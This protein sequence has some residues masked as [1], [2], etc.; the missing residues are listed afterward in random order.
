MISAV[1]VTRPA[2]MIFQKPHRKR[3]DVLVYREV[4]FNEIGKFYAVIIN[5]KDGTMRETAKCPSYN[6]A[7]ETGLKVAIN[8]LIK[9]KKTQEGIVLFLKFN[10]FS[11]LADFPEGNVLF[12][13][14]F[15]HTPRGLKACSEVHRNEQSDLEPFDELTA[16]KGIAVA[17]TSIYGE[18]HHI[19]TVGNLADVLQLAKELLLVSYRVK[20]LLHLKAVSLLIRIVV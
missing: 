20:H 3:M 14:K 6:Q 5:R 12:I 16:T 19:E 4:F 15:L 10:S 7:L 1:P 18:H 9:K 2:G 17:Y 8:F 13:R 11:F